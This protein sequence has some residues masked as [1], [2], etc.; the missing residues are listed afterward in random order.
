VRERPKAIGGSAVATLTR[1]YRV[2]YSHIINM[3]SL[4]YTH[5][6]RSRL[7]PATIYAIK[8]YY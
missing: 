8:Y 7:D 3:R 2:R 1:E 5:H 4:R 6:L